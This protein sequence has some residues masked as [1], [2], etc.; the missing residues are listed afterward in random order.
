MKQFDTRNYKIKHEI[1]K[2]VI[3]CSYM[4][5]PEKCY[6]DMQDFTEK[7]T[8]GNYSSC[9]IYKEQAVIHEHMRMMLGGDENDKSV[10]EIIK[11]VC[12]D[13][14]SG[15][16]FIKDSCRNCLGHKCAKVCRNDAI[17][18]EISGRAVINTKKCSE[19]GKC[20]DACQFKAIVSLKRPCEN[21]CESRAIS[22]NDKK[23][24]VISPD[25]C[26]SCGQCIKSCPDGAIEEKS[27]IY[28]AVQIIKR[29]SRVYAIVVPVISAHYSHC[30]SAQY[31]NALKECGFKDAVLLNEKITDS[32]DLQA[33]EMVDSGLCINNFCPSFVNYLNLNFSGVAG[34]ITRVPSPVIAAASDIKRND[35]NAQ[36]ILISPCTSMKK[37][38]IGNSLI[39][40]VITFQ[41]ADALMDFKGVTP[42]DMPCVENDE[43]DNDRYS[44]YVENK[45]LD[46]LFE[47]IVQQKGFSNLRYRTNICSGF[48]ECRTVLLKNS[49]K[50]SANAFICGFICAGGCKNG[51]GCV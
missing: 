11:P 50:I 1:L 5:K 37:E 47:N 29:S 23:N 36:V 33:G 9:C 18:F 41:E 13:C 34:N 44:Q 27:Y 26:I 2:K 7:I 48:D 6:S 45:R 3:D 40:C 25:K 38:F 43:P 51:S 22:I 35:K 4:D 16:Y 17:S 20:I 19:C 31:I 8:E 32:F 30:K 24:A 28:D 14:H 49:R 39:D 42:S 15:G 21:A 12:D 46:E 10:I